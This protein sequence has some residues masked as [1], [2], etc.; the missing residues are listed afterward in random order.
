MFSLTSYHTVQCAGIVL[1]HMQR[2]PQM[3]LGPTGLAKGPAKLL[4]TL[5]L[6]AVDRCAEDAGRPPRSLY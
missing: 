4:T 3:I 1:Q 5:N 6:P 2:F